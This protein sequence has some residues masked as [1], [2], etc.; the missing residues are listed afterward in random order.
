MKPFKVIVTRDITE[1]VV[2]VVE[3]EN[4]LEA[5]GQALEKPMGLDEPKWEL[6]LDSCQ[7]GDIYTTDVTELPRTNMARAK[8]AKQLCALMEELTGVDDLPSQVSDILC[9]L[10]HLCRLVPDD[11]G[12]MM[13]FSDLLMSAKFNFQAECEE[14]PDV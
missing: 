7:S 11:Y 8:E 9:N 3:A 13:D 6:D 12:D 1:S 14:D 2:V 4:R 5:S 10:M